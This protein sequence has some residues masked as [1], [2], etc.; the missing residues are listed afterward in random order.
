MITGCLRISRESIFTGL[1]N[2]KIVSI[3]SDSYAEY[4]GFVP[5][6]V[7]G[8]LDFYG[9]QERKEEAKRWYDGYLFGDT[10]AYNPWSIINYVDELTDGDTQFP[11]PYWSNTSSNSIIRE[12]VDHAGR[13]QKMEI[14]S[15]IEG[16]DY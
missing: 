14:E 1:N 10:E 15:L 13:E 12:M 5:E 9:L 6:E 11:K 4:F 8:M 16:G 2:L 7:E 3:I